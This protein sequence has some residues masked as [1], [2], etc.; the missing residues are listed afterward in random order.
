M[1]N[2]CVVRRK[3]AAAEKKEW[4]YVRAKSNFNHLFGFYGMSLLSLAI[5]SVHPKRYQTHNRDNYFVVVLK[6][7]VDFSFFSSSLVF[8]CNANICKIRARTIISSNEILHTPANILARDA[9]TTH[10]VQFFARAKPLA[11][12]VMATPTLNNI[13]LSLFIRSSN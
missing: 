9:I 8:I 7:H 10:C 6:F 11:Q 5:Q 13:V 4:I 3:Q 2:L 12:N 1:S